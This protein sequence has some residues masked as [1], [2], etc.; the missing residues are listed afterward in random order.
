MIDAGQVA[1]DSFEQ[2]GADIRSAM[3]M[4]LMIHGRCTSDPVRGAATLA[5]ECGE[6]ADAA[7]SATRDDMP[8]VMRV[9]YLQHMV[10]ELDQVAGYAILLRCE[11]E[12]EIER[13]LGR[14]KL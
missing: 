12:D 9:N 4:A 2:A 13:R 11:I 5:E 3:K 7:L 6:V 10:A 14:T 1:D 8:P